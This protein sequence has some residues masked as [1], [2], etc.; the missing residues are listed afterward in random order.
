MRLAREER[1]CELATG[2]VDQA[3]AHHPDPHSPTV[4]MVGA[5]GSDGARLPLPA[6]ASPPS[7]EGELPVPEHVLCP[8]LYKHWCM[9][10]EG[11]PPH[12]TFVAFRPI[13]WAGEGDPYERI[14]ASS[15]NELL[16][17]LFRRHLV[18]GNPEHTQMPAN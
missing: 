6:Q 8:L 2:L 5:I 4:R 15:R 18:N 17:L 7:F 10:I 11:K 14:T 3:I 16:Y 9:T 13:G 12:E 1:D